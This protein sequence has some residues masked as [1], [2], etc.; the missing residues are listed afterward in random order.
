MKDEKKVSQTLTNLTKK[1]KL[2][3]SLTCDSVDL[4]ENHI[5]IDK[6]KSIYLNEQY[7]KFTEFTANELLKVF[8]TPTNKASVLNDIPI[9]IIKNS[10]KDYSQKLI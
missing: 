7:F 5:S 9:N 1:R 10:A 3:P 2:K 4:F 6:I 8:T